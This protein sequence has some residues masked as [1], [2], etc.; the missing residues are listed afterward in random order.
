MNIIEHL[1]QQV[2][3]P[4]KLGGIDIS[5]TNGVITLWLAVLL[6]FIFYFLAGYRATLAPRRLQNIAEVIL[7]F[8]NQEVASQI[9]QEREKW[10]PFLTCIFSFILINNLLGL[11]PGLSGPTTNINTT[12]ALAI[13]IFLIVQTVGVLKHGP[14]GYIK[15]L[16]PPGIP[17]PIALFILPIELIGQL[18]R[19]FSLSV[20]LFA[21]MFAGHAVMLLIISLIF[22]FRSYIILPLPI[23]GN[24]AILFFE[25]FVAFIQAFVFT[26]LSALY[27][28]SAQEGH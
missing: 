4:L 7:N 3:F 19:P 11:V 28:G 26:Y 5:I 20:R 8:I 10:L 18:A 14:L 17:A 1:H 22:V 25:I 27:I 9:H 13:T 24:V 2:I 6:A 16:I 12:A 21:N 23:I 15:G